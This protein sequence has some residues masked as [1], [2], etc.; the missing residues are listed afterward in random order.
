[1][2]RRVLRPKRLLSWIAIST[3]VICLGGCVTTD[4]TTSAQAAPTTIPT[5]VPL[6]YRQL[7]A[8]KLVASVD[9]N[10]LVRAEISLPGEGWM[11]LINGGNRPM[12]CVTLTIDGPLIQQT[13]TA[14]FTFK[15]GQIDDVFSI[16]ASNLG[17]AVGAAIVGATTCDKFT[18]VPFP[19]LRRPRK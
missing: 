7:I 5:G 4:P 1:M 11:G 16:G 12:A 2:G 9:L 8:S 3:V 19:E 14:G 6:N 15:N 17:G 18:Y 10:R 13:Q